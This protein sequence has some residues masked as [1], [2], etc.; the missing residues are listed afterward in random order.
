V[1]FV[2]KSSLIYIVHHDVI[3]MILRASLVCYGS[4][5]LALDDVDLYPWLMAMF[6]LKNVTCMLSCE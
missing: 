1:H 2:G 6:F 4:F 5:G 3:Y